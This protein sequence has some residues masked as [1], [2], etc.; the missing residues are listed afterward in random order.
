MPVSIAKNQLPVVASLIASGFAAG[1][2]NATLSANAQQLESAVQAV[3]ATG[4][5]PVLTGA[6]AYLQYVERAAD[7]LMSDVGSSAAAATITSDVQNLVA[8]T[9]N[10]LAAAY[11]TDLSNV[12]QSNGCPADPTIASTFQ[13]TYMQSGLAPAIPSATGLYD[14]P[15]QA[16]VAKILGTASAACPMTSS[17]SGSSSSGS[18]GGMTSPPP[19][20]APPPAI[21]AP[22]PAIVA[23]V[24]VVAT[25]AVALLAYK[26]SEAAKTAPP[27]RR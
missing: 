18:G 25:A 5:Y 4:N 2:P 10:F 3:S 17:S 8:Q 19:T 12:V 24:A 23:T 22:P 20:V 13:Q 21:V 16:A 7:Q 15:T 26:M 6:G 11:A 9:L 1:T 14:A 27:T